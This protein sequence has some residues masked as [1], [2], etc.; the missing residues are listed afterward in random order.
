MTTENLHPGTGVSI[1]DYEIKG[2]TYSW[3]KTSRVRTEPAFME[4]YRESLDDIWAVDLCSSYP[5]YR[6]IMTGQHRQR[7][8]V[9]ARKFGNMFITDLHQPRKRLPFTNTLDHETLEK[10]K[11]KMVPKK[12]ITREL[13]N[14]AIYTL[15]LNPPSSK[16]RNPRSVSNAL[17]D[18]L[19]NS[20]RCLVE[21]I[22]PDGTREAKG[23]WTYITTVGKKVT[24]KK[25]LGSILGDKTEEF[26]RETAD[27]LAKKLIYEYNLRRVDFISLDNAPFNE[28]VERAKSGFPPRMQKTL[29]FHS[30]QRRDRHVRADVLRLPFSPESISFMTSIEGWPYYFTQSGEENISIARQ[31]SEM[32]VPGGKAVFFPWQMTDN[33]YWTR[34]WLREIEGEWEKDG[35]EIKKEGLTTDEMK[36][37]MT[38]R[39]YVLSD[40]SPLFRYSGIL[41]TLTLSKPK[42]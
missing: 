12:D 13:L 14:T 5:H 27:Y 20:D 42:T 23:N 32:L 1:E 28:I 26:L 30:A 37:E 33:F 34:K 18:K 35:L 36:R 8:R 4:V 19:M 40:H 10:L 15:M 21:V 39:E 29:F 31:I 17:F 3:G 7:L 25:I 2:G 41:T 6:E 16:K 11:R 24:L 9:D 38:D 22:E